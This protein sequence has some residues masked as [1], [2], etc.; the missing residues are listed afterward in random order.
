MTLMTRAEE[1]RERRA[2]GR[3]HRSR[4]LITKLSSKK[5][6]K[7]TSKGSKRTLQVCERGPRRL[8]GCKQGLMAIWAIDAGLLPALLEHI[9][10]KHKTQSL[11]LSQLAQITV[12]D[13]QTLIVLANDDS[14]SEP[15][16][17][18]DGFS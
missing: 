7:S 8:V 17:R 10:I 15:R 5:L 16:Q 1:A 11:P 12:K 2:R 6:R 3:L 9:V 18:Q 4:S 14:V 13:Q